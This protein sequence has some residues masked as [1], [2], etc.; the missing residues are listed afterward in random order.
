MKIIDFVFITVRF[1]LALGILIHFC[2]FVGIFIS[3]NSNDLTILFG[4][5]TFLMAIPLT[6]I[7]LICFNIKY[8]VI[9]SEK[10]EKFDRW[11]FAIFALSWVSLLIGFKFL[12]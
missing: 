5:Y 1:F 6:I 9:K 8:S 2:V 7:Y 11:E 3:K 12:M 10:I 4:Y